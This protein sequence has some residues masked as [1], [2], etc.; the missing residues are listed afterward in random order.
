[1]QKKVFIACSSREVDNKYLSLAEDIAKIFLERGFTLSFGAS[2]H[3]MMG[4][5]YQVFAKSNNISSHTVAKY[6]DDLNNLVGE[7][8]IY[9]TTFERTMSLYQMADFIIFLPGGTGTL[10]EMFSVIEENRTISN[11]KKIIIYN[12]ENYYQQVF[13]MIQKFVEDGFN[14][15]SI[16]EYFTIISEKDELLKILDN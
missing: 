15:N 12:Y 3:G 1:M 11:P 2:S 16:Y 6:I 5:C 4:K 7:K 10:T 9:N 13:S 14:D 8:Y